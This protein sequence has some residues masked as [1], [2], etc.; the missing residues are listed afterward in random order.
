LSWARY[1]AATQTL[2]VRGIDQQALDNA[3]MTLDQLFAGRWS[4]Q[5]MAKAELDARIEAGMPWIGKIADIDE[6]S[7]NRMTSVVLGV[8][9]GL[10]EGGIPWRMKDNSFLMLDGPGMIAM[11]SAAFNYVAALRAHYWD[12]VD[13]T[14]AVTDQD[15]LDLIDTAAGWPEPPESPPV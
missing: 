6:S 11:A 1:D 8:Q 14:K 10:G 3:L 5:S 2:T 12:L 15:G 4:K 7:Q 13:Q 9:V